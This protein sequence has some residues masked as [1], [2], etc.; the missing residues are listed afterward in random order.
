M[1]LLRFVL[2]TGEVPTQPKLLHP[3]E[4]LD[5]ATSV[6]MLWELVPQWA[7]TIWLE[8]PSLYA[9]VIICLTT[10]YLHHRKPGSQAQGLVPAD[11]G[12]NSVH[13]GAM[14]NVTMVTDEFI[15]VFILNSVQE[16][17][18]Q[19]IALLSPSPYPVHLTLKGVL[20]EACA[21]VS[22]WVISDALGIRNSVHCCKI[23]ITLM[24]YLSLAE[25]DC[26]TND[27]VI[28]SLTYV[29]D[30]CLRRGWQAVQE[31]GSLHFPEIMGEALSLAKR[32]LLQD[33]M[34]YFHVTSVTQLIQFLT[35]MTSKGVK[36]LYQKDIADFIDAVGEQVLKALPHRTSKH[37][38]NFITC[39]AMINKHGPGF[40]LKRF[41]P[42]SDCEAIWKLGMSG[43][44][45]NLVL[46]AA[47]SS[48]ITS[49]LLLPDALTCLEAWNHLIDIIL[50]ICSY[51]YILD[52]EPLALVFCPTICDALSHLL[53]HCDDNI[54]SYILT[55]PRTSALQS[56]LKCLQRQDLISGRY[57]TLLKH[58]LS[59]TASRLLHQL[60]TA[61]NNDQDMHGKTRPAEKTPEIS[62]ELIFYRHRGC[63]S[64]R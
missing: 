35:V 46:S 38:E 56:M 24:P 48:Y 37:S 57:F 51:N 10:T 3:I 27:L 26:R 59:G 47:F 39:L 60:G 8:Y 58:R 11:S 53:G 63:R 2:Y 17:L 19:F 44:S 33:D 29:Q 61:G 5:A 55:D 52:D 1:R 64:S 36:L 21:L 54:V 18:S 9:D 49:K 28:E 15:T 41:S 25:Q 30:T 32:R 40:A 42:A 14:I 62:S 6:I 20:Y 22:Q 45:T 23:L 4:D 7:W 34:D 31:N 43:K 50:L 12:V 16:L 13:Q